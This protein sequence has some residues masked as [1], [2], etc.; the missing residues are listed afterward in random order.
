MNKCR[1]APAVF[2]LCTSNISQRHQNFN[3]LNRTLSIL[4]ILH[5]PP[6][7]NLCSLIY[8]IFMIQLQIRRSR[9]FERGVRGSAPYPCANLVL[10]Q[11]T[12]PPFTPITCPVMNEAFSEAR[13]KTVSAISRGSPHLP[14]GISSLISSISSAV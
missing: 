5:N 6:N 10:R 8:A 4:F 13:K 14:R 11:M 3:S 9:I 2:F 12:I 1:L 7:M